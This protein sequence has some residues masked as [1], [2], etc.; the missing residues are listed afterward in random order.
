MEEEEPHAYM[1]IQ[2]ALNSKNRAAQVVQKMEHINCLAET[3][4]DVGSG[5]ADNFKWQAIRERLFKVGSTVIAEAPEFA[6]LAQAVATA[7][8]G[9]AT[10]QGGY[11]HWA[12]MKEFHETM[13][14]P[15][16][17]RV[18]LQTFA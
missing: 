4:M 11:N 2:E 7:L 15:K 1:V 13:I 8:G 17:R 16:T 12:E 14:N 6:S 18:R 10:G 9:N 5:M 3:I